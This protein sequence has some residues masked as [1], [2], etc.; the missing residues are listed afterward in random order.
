MGGLEH[1]V[2]TPPYT[3]VWDYNLSSPWPAYKFLTP[4]QV[5]PQWFLVWLSQ[6]D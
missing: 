6:T 1:L 3:E 5:M 4:A 2:L